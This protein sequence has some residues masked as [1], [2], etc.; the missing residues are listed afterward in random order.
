[1]TTRVN[2]GTPICFI[3]PF[4]NHSYFTIRALSTTA[5]VVVF[6]PPLQLQLL[7]R[8]WSRKDLSLACVPFPARLLHTASILAFLFFRARLFRHEL[9]LVIF[10]FLLV[11][12]L[13]HIPFQLRF[14][15]YQ[16]Y[17]A[18]LLAKHYPDSLRI[19]ELIIA[20]DSSQPNYKT[21]LA[22]IRHSSLIVIPS[23][24]LLNL[25]DQSLPQPFLAPYGGNKLQYL[26]N[27]F[28]LF[29]NTNTGSLRSYTSSLHSQPHVIRIVARSHS[30]RKGADIFL[31]SLVILNQLLVCGTSS[32]VLDV[33]VCGSIIEDEIRDQ[34][35]CVT[36]LLRLDNRIRVQSR[37]YQPTSYARLLSS[38]DLFLMPSRLESTSLAALEALWFGIPS[39]LTPQCGV[40]LFVQDRHGLQLVP[41]QP[42]TLAQALFDLST[43]SD[44]REHCRTCLAEDRHLFS[45]NQYFSSYQE[46]LSTK[47]SPS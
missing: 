37:Q 20:T 15:Y 18:D 46:I 31:R 22:A 10:R 43:S 40:D 24:S 41:N 35:K 6:C 19:C 36:N 39:I 8:R 42:D 30:H 33:Y 1:M 14:V 4:A 32:A 45:W 47:V 38:A 7:I 9:Y 13:R 26:S 23:P 21:T 27:T 44:I 17:V 5:P 29:S 34:F 25:I 28:V 16:D 2:P 11:H 12:F 3:N